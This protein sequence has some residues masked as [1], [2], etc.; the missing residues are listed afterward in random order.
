MP[1]PVAMRELA[2]MRWNRS[3]TRPSE[4]AGMPMPVSVTDSTASAR[5]ERSETVILPAGVYLNA[6]E[7]TLC[8]ILSHRSGLR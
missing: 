4:S 8:T 2:S 6:F 3:N 1:V 7:M 5:V